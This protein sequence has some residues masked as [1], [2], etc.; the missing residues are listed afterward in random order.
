MLISFI[1]LLL[2]YK[3]YGLLL[4]KELLERNSPRDVMLHLSRV[5]KL[6]IGEGWNLSEVPKASKLL[7]ERLGI[8]LH[9]TQNEQ[10]YGLMAACPLRT[11]T[12][13]LV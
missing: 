8:E 2:Y 3:V 1:S 9:I 7:A 12:L 6:R 5:Y 4:S 10:S 13:P 11:D